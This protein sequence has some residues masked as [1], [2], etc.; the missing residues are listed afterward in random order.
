MC[1]RVFFF[2]SSIYFL[3]G[4]YNLNHVLDNIIQNFVLPK[5]NKGLVNQ[6]PRALVKNSK[7]EVFYKFYMDKAAF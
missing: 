5:L 1:L 7:I 4:L 3:L 6:C 2:F